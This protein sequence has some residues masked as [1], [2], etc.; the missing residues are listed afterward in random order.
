[1]GKYSNEPRTDARLIQSHDNFVTNEDEWQ[2]IAH[3]GNED[4]ALE[5]DAAFQAGAE[6]MK[7]EFAAILDRWEEHAIRG[8]EV[9]ASAYHQGKIALICDLR[10]WLKEQNNNNNDGNI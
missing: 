9:G 4:A 1:M 5:E 2:R 3:A 8:M 10:E 7:K 6:W